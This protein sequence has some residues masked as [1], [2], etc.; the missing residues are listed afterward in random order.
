[1]SKLAHSHQSTMDEIE[2]R[3]MRH[4]HP[5][6]VLEGL[7]RDLQQMESRLQGRGFSKRK[8]KADE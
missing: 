4:D 1:M 3:A 8:V 5:D 2:I 6:I 7:E